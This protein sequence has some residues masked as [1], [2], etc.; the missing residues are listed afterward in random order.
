MPSTVEGRDWSP[1]LRGDEALTGDEAAL[2]NMPVEF[3]ELIRN[4]MRAY[5]GLRSARHTYVRNLDGPWL[6]YD[7]LADPYQKR[8]L[9]GSAGHA[10]LRDEL[11]RRLQ[12]RLDELGDEFLDG[13]IYLERAGLTHYK[14]ALRVLR[15]RTWTDPWTDSAG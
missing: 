15:E 12:R 1:L 10:E 14:E 8:N 5:R 2:L 13:R 11:D 6:L 9:I 4:D 3:T 7:N